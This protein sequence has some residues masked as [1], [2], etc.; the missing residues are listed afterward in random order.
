[1]HCFQH[2]DTLRN[3]NS[4][5]NYVLSI[6]TGL[7]DLHLTGS[8]HHSLTAYQQTAAGLPAAAPK[9]HSHA[10][11][12]R[13][14]AGMLSRLLKPI[15]GP[16]A[17]AVY[18]NSSS[19]SSLDIHSSRSR[20][21]VYSNLRSN[22]PPVIHLPAHE[23]GALGSCVKAAPALP[24]LPPAA[25][26][27]AARAIQHKFV[28]VS[29]LLAAAAA[30]KPGKSLQNRSPAA[31]A[32]AVQG[33]L[34]NCSSSKVLSRRPRRAVLLP[35]KLS[36]GSSSRGQVVLY[37]EALQYLAMQSRASQPPAAVVNMLRAVASPSMHV[38]PAQTAAL[39]WSA[40]GGAAS[41]PQQ[42]QHCAAG[43]RNGSSSGGTSRRRPAAAAGDAGGNMA[44]T[45]TSLRLAKM[46]ITLM[47]VAAAA[48]LAAIALEQYRH[49]QR[50]IS[51]APAER[52]SNNSNSALSGTA[53]AAAALT[54][55]SNA[56][57]FPAAAGSS[58][59]G[60]SDVPE[61]EYDGPG[62]YEWMEK[63][64]QAALQ[65][66]G[67]EQDMLRAELAML[68]T[69]SKKTTTVSRS[70]SNALGP[71]SSAAVNGVSSSR[72][73]GVWHNIRRWFHPSSSSS[74]TVAG[75]ASP[76]AEAPPTVAAKVMTATAIQ[77]RIAEI[78]DQLESLDVLRA[79]L[80]A[81]LL[82]Q[83]QQ[84]RQQD[85]QQMSRQ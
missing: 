62:Y 52:G 69:L 3:H 5:I 4:N 21:T 68:Q 85:V 50:P 19:N 66:F 76:A 6:Q 84:Q 55:H 80:T 48:A 32:V 47:G 31:A 72:G 82:D 46:G 8:V 39:L 14:V 73:D 15:R 29:G 53:A 16:R 57:K 17:L 61:G 37:R 38:S 23:H 51:A 30:G 79:A 74:G 42:M 45:S 11:A 34:L 1:M 78:Q 2:S 26:Q 13:A 7:Q 12:S 36:S 10:P 33:Y 40:G 25:V 81:E 44:L 63:R 60:S 9:P 75:S 56:V 41:P 24:M 43:N 64:L 77:S 67:A 58:K 54:A 20:L 28:P 71:S 35:A 18:P 70:S 49:P 59:P 22:R 83:Q 27:A 65:Q